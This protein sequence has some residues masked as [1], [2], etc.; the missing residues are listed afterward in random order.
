MCLFS[1]ISFPLAGVSTEIPALA[2]DHEVTMKM[3]AIHGE[4]TREKKVSSWHQG[5][6]LKSW[7]STLYYVSKIATSVLFEALVFCTFCHIKSNL[8]LNKFLHLRTFDLKKL[9]LL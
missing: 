5:A 9:F 7:M 6:P 2:L 3:E 1:V 8:T 4:A